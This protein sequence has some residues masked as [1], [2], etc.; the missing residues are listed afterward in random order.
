MIKIDISED[1]LPLPKFYYDRIKS[2]INTILI[3]H[4]ME[5]S[6]IHF[7][8]VNDE[9]LSK[10]KKKYFN[11][12]VYTDVMAFNLE[13]EGKDI[14]GEIYIS[15][16]RILDN[17]SKFE[18]IPN[19]EFKRIVIH[20]VL[21]LIGYDDQT[22]KDKSKMKELENLYMSRYEMDFYS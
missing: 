7:V 3:D 1:Y 9:L 13:D 5:N 17:A 21:H 14:D 12:D 10:M 22:D 20:G 2:C 18:I 6:F 19:D 15:W 16:D 11:M 8:I 4:K